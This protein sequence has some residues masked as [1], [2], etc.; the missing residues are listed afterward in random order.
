MD[1]ARALTDLASRFTVTTGIVGSPLEPELIL[2]P[3]AELLAT[4][5]LALS[6][7]E[8]EN[9]LVGLPISI[10]LAFLGKWV[11]TLTPDL[12]A[13][14]ALD[15]PFGGMPIVEQIVGPLGL[16]TNLPPNTLMNSD[17]GQEAVPGVPEVLGRIKGTITPTIER[18][19]EVVKRLPVELSIEWRVIDDATGKPPT[20]VTWQVH[21][22]GWEGTSLSSLGSA[23]CPCPCVCD[24]PQC[25]VS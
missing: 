1:Y 18:L 6:F 11:R 9:V 2:Q 7:T 24:F 23:A 8:L 16:T 20:D 4:E 10:D 17:V 25:S 19:K 13:D 22:E 15:D 21:P 3:P 12:P 14:P 5:G